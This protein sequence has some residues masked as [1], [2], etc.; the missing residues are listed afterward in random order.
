[1]FSISTFLHAGAVAVAG[2]C[3]DAGGDYGA[4][5][6]FRILCFTAQRTNNGVCSLPVLNSATPFFGLF[7]FH[8][9]AHDCFL[10]L[11]YAGS[12]ARFRALRRDPGKAAPVY[13]ENVTRT[14]TPLADLDGGGDQ[15]SGVAATATDSSSYSNSSSSTSSSNGRKRS[16]S[17]GRVDGKQN[18][19]ENQT[20]AIELELGRK[21]GNRK[22]GD[23]YCRA[24]FSRQPSA[25]LLEPVTVRGRPLATGDR[26]MGATVSTPPLRKLLFSATLTNN[27]QKLAGLGVVNPLIYTA[28]EKTATS[29]T[30]AA[31]SAAGLDIRGE[32][33]GGDGSAATASAAANRP[34]QETRR[35]STLDEIAEGGGTGEGRF[36][37][38][39]TLDETYTVCDSQVIL[40][41]CGDIEWS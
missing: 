31:G 32:G 37:T 38:P 28:R 4:A 35:S 30:A 33:D 23:N 3:G 18:K 34:S 27:P 21:I 19:N 26:V 5:D 12:L 9:R 29:R 2:A 16:R 13:E 24:T 36:S 11:S 1:M 20:K 17:S 15:D 14:E 39:A 7:C 41:C 10:N 6:T 25:V 8:R 40:I 22:S